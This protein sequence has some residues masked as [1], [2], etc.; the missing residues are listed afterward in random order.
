MPSASVSRTRIGSE[1]TGCSKQ[2]HEE[3]AARRINP[4]LALFNPIQRQF[5]GASEAIPFFGA[6][7]LERS[8]GSRLG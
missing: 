8:T 2:S 4:F 7:W 5:N 3:L 6:P 1:E